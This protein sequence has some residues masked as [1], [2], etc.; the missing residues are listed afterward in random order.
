MNRTFAW[1]EELN[2]L[3]GAERISTAADDIRLHSYDWWPVA[4]KWRQQGKQP[5]APLAVVH[6]ATTTD[7]SRLVR[8]AV[9]RHVCLTPWGAGSAVTGAALPLHGGLSVD[10]S[11]MSQLL[12][13]DEHNLLV[14]VQAGMMGHHLEEALNQRGYT[15]NHSPQSLHR[16]TVGGWVA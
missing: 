14:K 5:Y 4:A 16:S 7:V 10:M 6:P 9:E 8:W 1:L 3:L 12:E 13:F 2:D 11:A 15:L